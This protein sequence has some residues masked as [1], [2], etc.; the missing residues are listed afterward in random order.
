MTE[1][2]T[3]QVR[4][5]WAFLMGRSPI[6]DYL[7]FLVQSAGTGQVDIAAAAVRWH[8][9]A[10]ATDEL[11]GREAGAADGVAIAAVPVELDAYVSTFLNDPVVT[12]SYIAVPPSVGVIDLD[13]VVTFQRQVNLRYTEQLTRLIGDWQVSDLALLKFCLAIDQPEPQISAIQASANTFVF[14]SLSH[15]ARLL[16]ARLVD[17]AHIT[18]HVTAGRPHSAV[19]LQVG[20]GVNAISVVEVNGRWVLHNGTHRAYA[21]RAAGVTSIPAVILRVTRPDDLSIVPPVQQ[22]SAMYLGAARP[23]MLKDY[24]NPLL[25][26]VIDAPRRLRQ[27]RVQ[28][29]HE[30]SDI[31]G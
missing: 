23:P 18:G 17:A 2:V 19:V 9:A 14:S 10:R 16:E 24:F 15:D 20:Y 28:F 12:A 29:G 26:E 25:H 3:E 7:S 4:E 21:L 11:Q 22:N 30:Q 31:P 6:D 1:G 5:P 27:L 13:R 8:A